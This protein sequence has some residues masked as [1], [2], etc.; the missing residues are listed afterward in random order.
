MEIVLGPAM[1]EV[2]ENGVRGR[3]VGNV[4]VGVRG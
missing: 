4:V 2:G 3:W 1:V